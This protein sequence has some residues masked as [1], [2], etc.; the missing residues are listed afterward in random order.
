MKIEHSYIGFTYR[1]L[2]DSV[3]VLTVKLKIS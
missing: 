2:H 1:L 3:T